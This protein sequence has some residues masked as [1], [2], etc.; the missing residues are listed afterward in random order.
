MGTL[1]SGSRQGG[2]TLLASLQLWWRILE[3]S[4]PS[5]KQV[6]RGT[7]KIWKKHLDLPTE[8]IS[9]Y[10][11]SYFNFIQYLYCPYV[12]SVPYHALLV[13]TLHMYWVYI[14]TNFLYFFLFD[15]LAWVLHG[16]LILC[17]FFHL[18]HMEVP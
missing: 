10:K 3:R 15:I 11:N 9:Y 1:E 6:R 7:I 2:T 16:V 12:Y 8:I 5:L 18:C 14:F 17:T 13:V 4:T